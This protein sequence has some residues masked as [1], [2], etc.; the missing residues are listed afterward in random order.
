MV[1]FDLNMGVDVIAGVD[2]NDD[3]NFHTVVDVTGHEGAVHANGNIGRK[4]RE[5]HHS[6]FE[7]AVDLVVHDT[8]SDALTNEGMSSEDSY[9]GK[10]ASWTVGKDQ[11][12]SPLDG[13]ADVIV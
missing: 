8:G 5:V 13:N 4:E 7:T 11:I 9:H 12:V 10:V 1:G 6:A 2:V 3:V